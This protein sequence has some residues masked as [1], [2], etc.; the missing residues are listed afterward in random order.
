VWLLSA[1]VAKFLAVIVSELVVFWCVGFLGDQ[2]ES[3]GKLLD[4]HHGWLAPG[5]P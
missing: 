3:S 4:G 5:I 2:K 1:Q